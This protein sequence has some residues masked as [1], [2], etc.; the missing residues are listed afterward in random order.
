VLAGLDRH[1]QLGAD[2]VGGR[3]QQ[4]IAQAGR[5]EVEQRAETAELRVGAAAP[6]RACQRLDRVD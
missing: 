6:S 2:A 1:F 3:D 5:L 4:G